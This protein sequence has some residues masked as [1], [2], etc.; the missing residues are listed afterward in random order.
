M[1]QTKDL[2]KVYTP[3]KGV[4]VTALDGVSLTFPERG[5]V[6]LLGK[7]GSGKSTLLNLL[8][9]LD[10]Y[11]GGEIIIKG[12]SSRDFTQERFDSYRNTYV[13]FIF[14]DY[15]VLE[16]FT[17][18]ANIALAL[19][20]K[21]Q[22]PTDE[23]INK[24]LDDVD[25]TGY[26]HRRPNELSGGQLQRVAIARA[27]V[28][29][30][31]I[32]MADEPTGALD[33][34]TGKQVFDTL[35]KLSREKL[36][37]IVS[38]DREY[39]EYYA[40]RI[41]EL[42]DG[43][44]ISD[45]EYTPDASE[46]ASIT[47]DGD[48]VTVPSGYHLTEEDRVEI[49]A[50][51]DRLRA[52]TRLHFSGLSKKF[53]PTDISTIPPSDPS[54]FALI[55]SRL[56]L[57]SAFRIGASGLKYKKFRLVITILL[58][59]VAFGLFALAD[60]FGAYNHIEAC[61]N[62]LLE[63][64]VSYLSLVKAKQFE[65]YDGKLAYSS[66]SML[67]GDDLASIKRDMGVPVSGVFVPLAGAPDFSA[68]ID[69]TNEQFISKS[70]VL[71]KY[72]SG[73]S[74]LTEKTLSDLGYTLAA[75][76]IPDGGKD[77]LAVTT[78]TLEAFKNSGFATGETK[79]APDGSEVPVYDKI[80]SAKDLIGRKLTLGGREFEIV[81]VVD[82]KFDF[83]RYEPLLRDTEGATT[84]ERLIR[85]VLHEELNYAQN[86]S[87]HNL[88]F[89]GEGMVK[90]LIEDEP[91]EFPF[92]NGGLNLWCSPS[93]NE[94]IEIYP[95]FAGK[96]ADIPD[97]AKITWADGKARDSLGK[98]EI[99]VP[100]STV[101]YYS[102]T[103]SGDGFFVTND[104]EFTAEQYD[105][106]FGASFRGDYYQWSGPSTSLEDWRVVGIFEDESEGTAPSAHTI[107]M[108]DADFASIIGGDAG[109]YSFAV[110]AMPKSR[111]KIRN[112]AELTNRTDTEY[113][114]EMRNPVVY[115]LDGVN[116]VLEVLSNVFLWIGVGFAV[117]AS[118]M[119]ANFIGTSIAYKKQEIGILRAIGSRSSDVFNIFFAEGFIIAVINFILALAGA[120][121]ATLIINYYLRVGAGILVTVISFGIRQV[122]LL[123]VISLG[124]A[125]LSCFLPVKKIA[126]KRPIDAIRGR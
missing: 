109:D 75:G 71:C 6:F 95:E 76:R 118:I 121:T 21:G 51:I 55:K 67:D 103:V 48:T 27:L 100:Q 10:K 120:L 3:K 2:R 72:F 50:Y 124:V 93:D 122:A 106:I 115:E 35:K 29:N 15:N 73:Y 66:G 69:T 33:S 101:Q 77:E 54:K 90:K 52:G 57:H 111:N 96:L 88:A 43:H 20:L 125:A 37:I 60:T 17:V 104:M 62:S 83:S 86:Y 16:E 5:M 12:V 110:G 91:P 26:G 98:G 114:Y 4:P 59:V 102:S 63:S 34:A 126:S 112:I 108:S 80:G 117:F 23:I 24:I 97:G 28:K 38:H 44:V 11:D 119:L 13:G 7:S 46:S 123:I 70:A 58:S 79:K 8:G 116:E 39:A 107:Y 81:G 36:V 89:V 85:F 1:L 40:D 19:E 64:N 82:T 18:G 78:Y 53:R 94:T 61:T 30:P 25:L 22:K 74:E 68:Y 99:I 45:V 84:A 32:I 87:F 56:P 105:L 92:K 65:R 113:R 42:A 31:E 14:Q 9:G 47:Y 49:N 41:I